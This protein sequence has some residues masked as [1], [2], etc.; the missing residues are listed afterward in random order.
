MKLPII[1]IVI[2]MIVA[3][4]SC[5]LTGILQ[6]PVIKEHDFEYAVT[7]RL[8]GEVNTFNG[9]YKCSFD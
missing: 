4:V 7:Y 2:G 6:E 1:I 3:I 5:L 9:V 8:D